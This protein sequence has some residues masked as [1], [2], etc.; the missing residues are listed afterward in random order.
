MS[1]AEWRDLAN[2]QQANDQWWDT[3]YS[4]IPESKLKDLIQQA[5]DDGMESTSGKGKGSGTTSATV[6]K[7]TQEAGAMFAEKE[8]RHW[9]E[10]TAAA[11]CASQH[12]Q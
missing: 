8:T 5:N 4:F 3:Y 10:A 7:S 6:A 2:D 11:T 1:I 12:S 9:T